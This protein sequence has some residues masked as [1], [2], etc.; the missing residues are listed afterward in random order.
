M[1]GKANTQKVKAFFKKNIY[2]IVMVVCILAIAAMI[3]VAVVLG[4][5]DSV[6]APA[7]DANL[8][9]DVTEQPGGNV[10]TPDDDTPVDTE[11][12]P[13]VFT[14]PVASGTVIKD[15]A[16]DSLVWSSTLK[17][18]RV[19]SGIDFAG[20]EGAMAV[21]AYDGV[22]SD[23]TYDALNG[24]VVTVDHGDGLSTLYGSLDEPVVSKGQVVSASAQLGAIGVSATG[25][26]ADGDHLHFE[27]RLNGE[28]VSPYDYLTLGDK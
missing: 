7:P 17:Q 18:Y 20:A 11:P 14:I 1:K 3:T 13:I 15:Y 6:E 22:V 9:G 16:M 12:E 25:E 21:A 8:P 26:M 10:N 4:G 24:Y 27:V 23:I 5:K 19:H 28:V 2:Y